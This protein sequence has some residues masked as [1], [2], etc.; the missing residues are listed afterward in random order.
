MADGKYR[1]TQF[2]KGLWRIAW[3]GNIHFARNREKCYQPVIDVA[4]EECSYSFS[5]KMINVEVAVGQLFAL[6]TGTLWQDGIRDDSHIRLVLSK[7]ATFNIATHQVRLMKA[8]SSQNEE[9]E[10]SPFRLPF[11]HFTEHRLRTESWCLLVDTANTDIII[12]CT[13]ILRFYFASSS[14]LIKRIIHTYFNPHNI[15]RDYSYDEESGLLNIKLAP[16]ISGASAVDIGRIILDSYALEAVRMVSRS[17]TTSTTNDGKAY[18]KTQFPF[19][20]R[21][22]LKVIG[23]P[24]A[25][26]REKPRFVVEQIVSCSH[27]LP[28]KKLV[29]VC[30]TPTYGGY[31]TGENSANASSVTGVNSQSIPKE[32]TQLMNQEPGANRLTKKATWTSF[33]RFPDI[34]RKEIK[35]VSS[36]EKQ[37]IVVGQKNS[38]DLA[39]TGDGYGENKASK[40]DLCIS[41]FPLEEGK[42]LESPTN[43]WQSYFDFLMRLAKEPYVTNF[44]FIQLDDQQVQ[45][46]YCSMLTF[47]DEDGVIDERMEEIQYVSLCR[48]KYHQ[49][50]KWLF[51]CCTTGLKVNNYLLEN[52]HPKWEQIYEFVINTHS[53]ST[54]V[55]ALSFTDLEK[56]LQS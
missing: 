4:L 19:I 6:A 27:P 49:E 41:Y 5:C 14:N 17:L 35:R 16:Q 2:P 51:S 23:V 7:K 55:K 44:E 33:V 1:L 54:E 48:F 47:A 3:L 18:L 15:W 22:Q 43:E 30:H 13:E 38:S 56:K 24:L 32:I 10:S 40:V 26:E 8:G 21:S 46:H 42:V 36:S 28:F 52:F 53:D 12:P 29:Y 9:D 50:Q 20:G 31:K 11:T 34:L 37:I 25:I 45:K 39:S